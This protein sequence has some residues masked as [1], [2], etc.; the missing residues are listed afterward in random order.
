MVYSEEANDS[1]IEKKRR[2]SNEKSSGRQ[3]GKKKQQ[4]QQQL[5][6]QKQ[7]EQKVGALIAVY[8]FDRFS[9]NCAKALVDLD[10]WLEQGILVVSVTED[11]I[12]Y[13]T[14][15]GRMQMI[16]LISAAEFQSRSLGQKVKQAQQYQRQLGSHVGPVP[17]GSKKRKLKTITEPT[18]KKSVAVYGLEYDTQEWAVMRLIA[19]IRQGKS[20]KFINQQLYALVAKK[21]RTPLIFE[22]K[23]DIPLTTLQPNATSYANIAF[24]LNDYNL[25]RRKRKWTAH[26]VRLACQLVDKEDTKYISPATQ[27]KGADKKERHNVSIP[28]EQLDTKDKEKDTKESR[29]KA[30]KPLGLSTKNARQVLTALKAKSA[31]EAADEPDSRVAEML[32]TVTDRLIE[33][34]SRMFLHDGPS[35]QPPAEPM[36]ENDHDSNQCNDNEAQGDQEDEDRGNRKKPRYGSAGA[37][38]ISAPHVPFVPAQQ[39]SKTRKSRRRA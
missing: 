34:L 25:F 4:L 11:S 37:P 9:R 20:V 8:S 26:T 39:K 28:D 7:K 17:Y 36:S 2:E 3:R 12:D 21:D 14:P 13:S 33:K 15:A 16:N 30:K 6:Q 32:E 5:A 29:N 19:N 18:T 38:A 10:K 31:Q 27:A 24:I 23:K 22:G 1:I 35:A